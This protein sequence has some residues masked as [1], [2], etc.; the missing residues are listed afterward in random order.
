V[1]NDNP[2]CTLLPSFLN[3]L[4]RVMSGRARTVTIG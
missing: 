2:A 1:N 3:H 4:T